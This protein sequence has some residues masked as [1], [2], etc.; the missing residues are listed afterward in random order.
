[1]NAI[2]YPRPL[3]E[4][5]AAENER[6]QEQAEDAALAY[7]RSVAEPAALS[8]DAVREIV[9]VCRAAEVPWHDGADILTLPQR[10]RW[11]A[12]AYTDAQGQLHNA[13]AELQA[14]REWAA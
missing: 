9:D 8:A 2:P 5:E 7:V 6:A 4:R 1:M 11:L 14:Q 3:T 10:V 13:R 12:D